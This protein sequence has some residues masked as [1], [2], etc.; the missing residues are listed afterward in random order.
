MKTTK[1]KTFDAVAESRRWK[2]AVSRQTEGMTRAELLA[3]FNNARTTQP[4][5]ETE[6]TCILREEPPKP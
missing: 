5:G 1:T 3:F 4:R 6:E 2:Q